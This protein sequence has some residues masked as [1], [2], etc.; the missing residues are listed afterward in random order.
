MNDYNYVWEKSNGS[1]SL[2][3]KQRYGEPMAQ[4]SQKRDL[5]AKI[6]REGEKIILP[7]I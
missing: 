7:L 1:R 4:I 5:T 2:S 3:L 6:K